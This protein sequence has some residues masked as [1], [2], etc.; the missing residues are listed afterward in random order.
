MII[1]H[2]IQKNKSDGTSLKSGFTLI[3]MLIALAVTSVI[4]IGTYSLILINQRQYIREDSHRDLVSNVRAF[5]SFLSDDLRSAGAVLSLLHTGNYLQGEV[6]FNGIQPLNSFTYPDGVILA[7]GDPNATTILQDEDGWTSEDEELTVLDP[8]TNWAVNDLGLIMQK[9]GY[10][11]FRVTEV[12][13]H[14]LT[15]RPAAVYYSGLLSSS[16]YQDF[17]FKQF[18]DQL[19]SD[20]T[21]PDE[22]PVVRL[23]Y[24]NIYLARE[25]DD[26]SF[27]M[28][29]TSDSQG[30]ADL[31]NN[32]SDSLGIPL[33]ENLIDFQMDYTT[34]NAEPVIWASVRNDFSNQPDPC[35]NGPDDP[36]CIAFRQQFTSR[37]IGSVR[38]FM[39]A[40]SQIDQTRRPKEND[41][42]DTIDYPL[43]GDIF[44]RPDQ[45]RGS[46]HYHYNE[47][48]V[49]I[50][51]YR[52]IY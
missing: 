15:V 41:T 13:G 39:M 36:M 48:D 3:E 30:E 19:G 42:E 6:P 40:R 50:R 22:S 24:F 29:L 34:Q 12:A 16:H 35:G 14:T 17:L 8:T 11:V 28:T 45:E 46:Y 4:M 44:A 33:I 10:Y 32:Q 38:V 7:A 52:I 1:N 49:A 43:M 51:N 25:E 27:T 26:G 2:G 21:Y 5:Q 31:E 47:F 9:E 23:F 18:N 20:L 37:Q